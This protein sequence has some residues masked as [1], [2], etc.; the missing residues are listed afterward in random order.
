MDPVVFIPERL[1][2]Q[3]E[4]TAALKAVLAAHDDGR[5][6]AE[7]LTRLKWLRAELE[8]LDQLE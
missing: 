7:I 3:T 4:I 5:S 6:A 8:R 2:I 1:R